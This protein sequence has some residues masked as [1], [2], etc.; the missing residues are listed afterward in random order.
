MRAVACIMHYQP[1]TPAV[2]TVDGESGAEAASS[3][4]DTAAAK[5]G[6]SEA[7]ALIEAT[8]APSYATDASGSSKAEGR[9]HVDCHMSWYEPSLEDLAALEE[10]DF[11]H[12]GPNSPAQ[13]L[14]PRHSP[15]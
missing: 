5:G 3:S 11:L 7:A 14:T 15:H 2:H 13:R 6:Q 12:E 1:V 10:F 4:S 8:V 9:D